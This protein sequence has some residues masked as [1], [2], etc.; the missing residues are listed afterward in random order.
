MHDRLAQDA[1]FVLVVLSWLALMFRLKFAGGNHYVHG[2]F[3]H[4]LCVLQFHPWHMHLAARVQRSFHYS[5]LLLFV[6]LLKVQKVS[7]ECTLMVVK[8]HVAGLPAAIK[9]RSALVP[10]CSTQFR[11]L[12]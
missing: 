9:E 12:L 1:A 8:L 4:E 10:S 3:V 6:L 11:A 2:R 5:F 7:C